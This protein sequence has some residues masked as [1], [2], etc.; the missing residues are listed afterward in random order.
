VNKFPDFSFEKKLW[1]KE[2]TVI[3]ID[4]VGRGAFAGPVTVGGVV[5]NPKLSKKET[6]YILS[7]KIHDSK[8]L[9][10]KKREIL[11]TLIKENAIFYDLSFIDIDVINEIGISKATFLGMQKVINNLSKKITNPYVLVDAFNIPNMNLPQKGIIHGDSL[12][13]SIAAASIIAK[14]T[15]DSLMQSLSLNFEKYGW[16]EN[17]GYGTLKHRRAIAEFGLSKH[18]RIDFCRKVVRL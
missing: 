11:S 16:G 8:K 4:E 9:T 18:H 15:R 6:E 3:G 12:S 5:F 10:P 1:Q 2:F 7:L 17:K 13:V 14:V